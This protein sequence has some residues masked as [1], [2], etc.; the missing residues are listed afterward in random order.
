MKKIICF[1]FAFLVS[2][3]FVFAKDTY[4][5]KEVKGTA[6]YEIDVDTLENVKVGLQLSLTQYVEVSPNSK[7]VLEKDSEVIEIKTF[8]GTISD[9]VRTRLKPA[10]GGIKKGSSKIEVASSVKKDT[11]SRNSVSTASS[12]ASEAKEDLEWDDW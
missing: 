10:T 12:R 11:T 5:V 9:Y 4:T 7:L 8:K 3:G 1:I 2:I 6:R